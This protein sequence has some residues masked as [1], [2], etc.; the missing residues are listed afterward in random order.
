MSETSVIIDGVRSPLVEY[1]SSNL[2]E[3]VLFVHGNP[4]S[5]FDWKKLA[6]GAGEFGRAVAMDMPGFGAADKPPN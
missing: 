3:A 2:N 5:S 1:G 4:G 6:H